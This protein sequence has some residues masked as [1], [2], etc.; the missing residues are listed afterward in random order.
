M[1]KPV[2]AALWV[3]LALVSAWSDLAHAQH[4]WDADVGAYL[5][6]DF[7]G[8]RPGHFGFG[9]EV[10]GTYAPRFDCGHRA[11]AYAGVAARL[12]ILGRDQVRVLVAPLL[13]LAGDL[14]YPYPPVRTSIGAEL[15]LGYRL[16]RDPGA[17]L[18]P[19]LEGSL[20]N[21]VF[22]RVDHAFGRDGDTGGTAHSGSMDLGGRLAQ[23]GTH[24]PPTCD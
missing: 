16:K 4:E 3:G 19:G 6:Y 18:Q 14:P 12:T 7:G 15:G 20:E 10:R 23:S 17:F 11:G 1:T 24:A 2:Q 5:S 21:A 9:V 8:T 13:G 22:L